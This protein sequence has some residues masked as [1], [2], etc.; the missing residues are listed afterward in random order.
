MLDVSHIRTF[1]RSE[2]WPCEKSAAARRSVDAERFAPFAHAERWQIVR[3][4][5]QLLF[6]VDLS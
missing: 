5:L 4:Q 6:E 1:T 2:L 3:K